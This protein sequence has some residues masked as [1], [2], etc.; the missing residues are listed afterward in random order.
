MAC[1]IEYPTGWN[2]G[3]LTQG[4]GYYEFEFVRYEEAP[5]A[6]AQKVI[7]EQKAAEEE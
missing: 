1:S 4:R 6:V 5:A 7:A 3:S 2:E